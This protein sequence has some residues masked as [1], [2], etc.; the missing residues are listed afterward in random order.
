[1]FLT[2]YLA[3]IGHVDKD[4]STCATVPRNKCLTLMQYSIAC[5]ARRKISKE[6]FR[7]V[8]YHLGTFPNGKIIINPFIYVLR[9]FPVGKKIF[10]GLS[11]SGGSSV[12]PKQV[13]MG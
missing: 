11:A 1:M 2:P 12:R 13:V 10:S 7:E 4:Y 9:K 3:I 8:L 6:I 5:T